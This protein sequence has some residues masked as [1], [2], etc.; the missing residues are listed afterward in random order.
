[1]C[2]LCNVGCVCVLCR[3]FSAEYTCTVCS[4]NY[5][6]SFSCGCCLPEDDSC[7]IC[8][9]RMNFITKERLDDDEDGD[10]EEED[11]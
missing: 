11:F 1:M 8:A 3:K 6:V 5:E 4:E 10:E 2:P 7:M 9:K